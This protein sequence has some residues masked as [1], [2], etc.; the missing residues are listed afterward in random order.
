M[1]VQRTRQTGGLACLFTLSPWPIGKSLLL[2][3]LLCPLLLS[4]LSLL[5]AVRNSSS[6]SYSYSC[7]RHV[8]TLSK[9]LKQVKLPCRITNLFFTHTHTHPHCDTALHCLQ[10][11]N[12]I[13][14]KTSIQSE[15]KLFYSWRLLCI[16]NS[17]GAP[18][19]PDMQKVFDRAMTMRARWHAEVDAVC[20][21]CQTVHK[22]STQTCHISS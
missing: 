20:S 14:N 19:Q 6:Y 3:L 15:Y 22:P 13:R 1:P 8:A 10:S 5:S 12:K 17:S 2:S 18:K 9:H 21:A 7:L 16:S 4:L 11:H